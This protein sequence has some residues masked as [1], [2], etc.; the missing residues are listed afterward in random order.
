MHASDQ[1]DLDGCDHGR[2]PRYVTARGRPPEQRP[3]RP[4]SCKIIDPSGPPVIWHN[5]VR[6][7]SSF[8]TFR[9]ENRL[10][11]SSIKP[12]YTRLF[13]SPPIADYVIFTTRS[14]QN[15]ICRKE[16]TLVA[17]SPRIRSTTPWSLGGALAAGSFQ[18]SAAASIPRNPDHSDR[19][20]LVLAG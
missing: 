7:H 8:F 15:K 10:I 16:K 11:R 13:F 1:L 19:S 14:L 3:P 6:V 17:P 18:D 5:Y 9:D 20:N 12:I 4:P 2:A